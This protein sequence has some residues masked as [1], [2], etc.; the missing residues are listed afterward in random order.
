MGMRSVRGSIAALAL[1]AASLPGAAAATPEVGDGELA[2]HAPL[3]AFISHLI[4]LLVG[5]G[6]GAALWARR[7]RREVTR[8]SA[9]ATRRVGEVREHPDART[10]QGEDPRT[11]DMG[12]TQEPT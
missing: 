7:S 3:F 9:E 12:R 8:E 4:V 2:Y 6:L 11:S 10:S 1:A 5:A